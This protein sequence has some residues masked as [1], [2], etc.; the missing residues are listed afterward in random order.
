MITD[1]TVVD[2]ADR[3][4][5]LRDTVG[6][7]AIVGIAG[8]PGSGKSTLAGELIQRLHDLDCSVAGVP[9]DGFHLAD[10]ELRRLGM[11]DRKGAPETFDL[12]GYRTM[13]ERL[14]A[15]D[16][17]VWAPAFARDIEQPIAGSIPVSTEV[18]IVVTEGNYLLL[19]DGPW[20][21]IRPLLD[22]TWFCRLP[23]DVRLARLIARH[24]EFGKEP[25]AARLWATGP[26]Q[27]NAELIETT[28]A[29]ADL[30][31]EVA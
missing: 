1:P 20:A 24:V 16:E 22:E 29:R 19:S 4:V 2:L 13:L 6:R 5:R 7:R 27:R 8:A 15:R 9:M 26:D 31:V 23:E 18:S 17:D 28:G 10:V 30:L 25:E 14:R 3:V 11:L 12:G 21:A